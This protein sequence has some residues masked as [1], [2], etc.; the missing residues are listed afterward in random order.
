MQLPRWRVEIHKSNTEI[1]SKSKRALEIENELDMLFDNKLQNTNI[2]TNSW[3]SEM[4]NSVTALQAIKNKSISWTSQNGEILSVNIPAPPLELNLDKLL[5]GKDKWSNWDG[6][7]QMQ[8]KQ[9]K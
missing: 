6:I 2:L 5:F 1:Y 4:I 9:I 7:I 3:R 8:S